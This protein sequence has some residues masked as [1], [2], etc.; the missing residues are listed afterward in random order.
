MSTI[1]EQSRR[2]PVALEVDVAVLGAGVA[3]LAAAVASARAGARTVLVERFGFCGGLATGGLITVYWTLDDGDG[4]NLYSGLN[5]E[6]VR[7]L[8]R[9][10]YLWTNPI[11]RGRKKVS[12]R[13]GKRNAP[14]F[15]P[16]ALKLLADR[17]LKESRV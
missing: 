4:H 14:F 9:M 13:K 11:W 10:G 2:L 16:E 15:D 3:G 7:R 17:M 1:T 8:D 12:E 6:I 5:K